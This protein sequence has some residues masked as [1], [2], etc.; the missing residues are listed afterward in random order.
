MNKKNVIVILVIFIFTIIFIAIY[1]IY[2]REELQT[3]HVL[4]IDSNG[5]KNISHKSNMLEPGSEVSSN[6]IITNISNKK[7]NYIIFIDNL[8]GE[9]EDLIIFK[10]YYN[11]ELVYSEKASNFNKANAFNAPLIDEHGK[12]EYLIKTELVS[13]EITNEH[14]GKS[15]KFDIKISLQKSWL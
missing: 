3:K 5:F 10:I 12:H 11:N 2:D 9:I 7:V 1:M 4:E 6:F 8:D 13:P 15:L 14:Q